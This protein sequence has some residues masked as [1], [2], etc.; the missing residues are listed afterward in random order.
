MGLRRLGRELALK[1]LYQTEMS[2]DTS[3]EALGLVFAGFA[4]DQR[5][6]RFA[7]ELVEGARREQAELDRYIGEVLAHWSIKRLSRIDHNILRLALYELLRMP[8]IPARVTID[9]AIELA[10]RYGDTNSGQ[11]VNGVLDEIAGRA[12]LRNKGEE[13]ISA[14]QG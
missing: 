13:P 12:G 7:R 6:C 2:G 11:F 4:G 9:E 14:K 10:K 8:D 5:A 3:L 1:G